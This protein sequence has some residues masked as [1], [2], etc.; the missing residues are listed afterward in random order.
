V[1]ISTV[2]YN[3]PGLTHAGGYEVDRF[4]VEYDDADDTLDFRFELG[5]SVGIYWALPAAPNDRLRVLLVDGAAFHVDEPSLALDPFCCL[6]PRFEFQPGMQLSGGRTLVSVAFEAGLRP[7]RYRCEFSLLGRDG[8]D[9]LRVLQWERQVPTGLAGLRSWLECVV[10]H[11]ELPEG[12]TEAYELE[13]A[14]LAAAGQL[15]ARQRDLALA[16]TEARREHVDPSRA[17]EAA[18][19]CLAALR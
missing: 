15:D 19:A 16:V 6:V 5:V 1:A 18:R 17:Q 3:P 12:E 4:V 7:G 8:F 2:S 10:N 13:V 14:A 11:L 9:E